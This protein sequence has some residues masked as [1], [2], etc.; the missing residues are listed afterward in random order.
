LHISEVF[1]ATLQPF[2]ISLRHGVLD[3]KIQLSAAERERVGRVFAEVRDRKYQRAIFLN[4]SAG[5]LDRS[6]APEKFVALVAW[7][8]RSYPTMQFVVSYAPIEI[9]LAKRA[10]EAGG[11]NVSMLPTGLS[12]IDIIGLI[13]QFDLVISVDT[14]ICHIA[15]KLDVPLLA[16]YN[17]NNVNFSRWRPFGPRVWAVRSP[18]HKAVDGITLEQMQAAVADLFEELFASSK[19]ATVA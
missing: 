1:R 15:A 12:I 8:S 4:A 7:L 18:D 17:G 9:E 19:R 14:S 6:W 5:K 2:G 10:V 3:G 13:S 11:A 16:L